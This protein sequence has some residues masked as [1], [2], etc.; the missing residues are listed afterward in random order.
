MDDHKA[1]EQDKQNKLQGTLTKPPLSF[2]SY[3]TEPNCI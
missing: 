3:Q 2:Y 1:A